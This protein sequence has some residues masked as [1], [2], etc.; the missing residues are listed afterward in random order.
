[1]FQNLRK[2]K[3]HN[4]LIIR[5]IYAYGWLRV[6]N[7]WSQ[8]FLRAKFAKYRESDWWRIRATEI[9]PEFADEHF[10][11]NGEHRMFDKI[12]RADKKLMRRIRF[13]P[14]SVSAEAKEN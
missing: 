6:N 9:S 14:F 7:P 13:L 5:M 2:K 10:V 4:P 8:A 3:F 11:H 1:M 12:V